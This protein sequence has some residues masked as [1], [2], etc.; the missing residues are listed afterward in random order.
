MTFNVL[1]RFA[2]VGV[3]SDVMLASSGIDGVTLE[4]VPNLNAAGGGLT[5]I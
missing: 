2:A 4:V 3:P 5:V 1:S